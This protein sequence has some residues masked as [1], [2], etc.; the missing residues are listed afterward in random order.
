MVA[1]IQR[2]IKGNQGRRQGGHVVISAI[3]LSGNALYEA[4]G[5]RCGLDVG[6]AHGGGR[7][8]GYLYIALPVD[9]RSDAMSR[10]SA[11]DQC[12]NKYDAPGLGIDQDWGS[13]AM[14]ARKH[15][16]EFV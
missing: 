7:M 2:Q 16:R 4:L 13:R 15:K 12:R 8:D 1:Y 5:L 10:G 14:R 9:C 11:H 6:V 3:L